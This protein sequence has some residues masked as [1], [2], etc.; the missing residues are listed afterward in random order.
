VVTKLDRLS[1]SLEHLIQLSR[2]LE[3]RTVDLVVLDQIAA[4][5]GVTRP[6]IYRHLN[7]ATAAAAR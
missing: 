5:F 3:R 1:R 4:E 7:T 6:T 2:E